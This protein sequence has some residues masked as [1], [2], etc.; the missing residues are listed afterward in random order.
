MFGPSATGSA[1][2]V[3]DVCSGVVRVRTR[4]ERGARAGT[5]RVRRERGCGSALTLGEVVDDYRAQHE[6]E[7]ETV[8]KLRSNNCPPIQRVRFCFP[9]PAVAT[10]ICTTSA[11]AIGNPPST[12]PGLRRYAGFTIYAI[13]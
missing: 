9:Q 7:R 4:R 5:G 6:G 12:P 10:S 3:P 11:T 13:P 8:E 2:A 1:A